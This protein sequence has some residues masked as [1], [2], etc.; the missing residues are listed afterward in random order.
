MAVDATNKVDFVAW[1]PD[2]PTVRLVIADHLDWENESDHLL[3]LQSKLNTYLEIVESG[4]LLRDFPDTA[5][6]SVQ[7]EV[8]FLHDPP[9]NTVLNFLLPATEVANKYCLAFTW[10]FNPGAT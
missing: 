10:A 5:G 6:K 8:A 4:Q 2:M 1:R 7:I 9:Q 3:T